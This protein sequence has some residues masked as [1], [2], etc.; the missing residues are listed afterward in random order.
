MEVLHESSW[1]DEKIDISP[2]DPRCLDPESE[3]SLNLAE[4]IIKLIAGPK[5][6]F[7]YDQSVKCP[8]SGLYDDKKQQYRLCDGLYRY[9]VPRSVILGKSGR[10]ERF[11]INKPKSF[12]HKARTLNIKDASFDPNELYA[13]WVKDTLELDSEVLER[14]KQE[15]GK[16]K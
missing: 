13:K 5:G 14:L 3:Y 15:A 8:N 6:N 16:N 9:I 12:V 1:D 2:I 11:E 10:V 7:E 4:L